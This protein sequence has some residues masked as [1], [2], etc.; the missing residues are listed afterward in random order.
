[1]NSRGIRYLATSRG[2]A[3][4]GY[5]QLALESSGFRLFLRKKGWLVCAAQISSQ[6]GENGNVTLEEASGIGGWKRQRKTN[7]Q[8]T[9]N[10][11]VD[12]PEG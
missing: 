11:M 12:A 5:P 2:G 9:F 7:E 6:V 1:M 8:H 10:K 3:I 4:V